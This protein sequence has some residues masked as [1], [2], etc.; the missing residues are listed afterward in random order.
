MQCWAVTIV[1]APLKKGGRFDESARN[2]LERKRSPDV[3]IW[4]AA[5]RVHAIDGE[6][7][8]HGGRG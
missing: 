3:T 7:A 4:L 5:E 2:A 8:S 6:L 1:A